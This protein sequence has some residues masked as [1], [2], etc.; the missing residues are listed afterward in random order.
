MASRGL[1]PRLV[2]LIWASDLLGG[3]LDH[4][5]GGALPP[6]KL[7]NAELAGMFDVSEHW[8]FQLTGIRFR[9]IVSEGQTTSSLAIDACSQ[10]IQEAG[11]SAETIDLVS[12]RPRLRFPGDGCRLMITS[13]RDE[14]IDQA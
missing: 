7:D 6:N 5:V 10:A 4:G 3:R 14:G 12:L 11:I 2:P 1:L 8:I 13:N 9:R